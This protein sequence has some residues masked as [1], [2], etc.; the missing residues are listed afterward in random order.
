MQLREVLMAYFC[1][2]T[3]V[4]VSIVALVML[5]MSTNVRAAQPLPPKVTWRIVQHPNADGSS[6]SKVYLDVGRKEY[7]IASGVGEA[8]TTGGSM[9]GRVPSS[10][11]SACGGWWAGT[12][13]IYYVTHVGHKLKV[14]HLVLDEQAQDTTT[15]LRSIKF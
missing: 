5:F 2:R 14:Y 3:A 15:L 7:T 11:L 4:I 13:D 12:G 10:A 8:I 9:P 6:K 1:G